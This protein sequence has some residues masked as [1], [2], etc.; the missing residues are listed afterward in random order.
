MKD[1]YL[2]AVIGLGVGLLILLPLA[3]LDFRL[4]F[5]LVS[6]LIV[7][8]TILGPVAFGVFYWLGRRRPLFE[9]I[10]KFAAI[11]TLNTFLDLGTVNFFI[12]LTGATAGWLFSSFKALSFILAA[13][14]SYLWNK[15]WTF[16]SRTPAAWREYLFFGLFT[17]L[18]LL[19][20][21]AIASF[22]VNVIGAPAGLSAALWANIAALIATAVSLAFNF[23]LYK[24]AVFG[25]K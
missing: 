22:L 7:G 15:F 19:L 16:Q 9:Q 11:G 21:V 17:F 1:F 2:A 8:F 23:L 18:G 24:K 10:G 6:L 5:K 4:T 12:M 20:N 13:T 3:N 25:R 14:N